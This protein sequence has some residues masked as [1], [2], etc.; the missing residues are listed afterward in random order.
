MEDCHT[1]WV[2]SPLGESAGGIPRLL[3][4]VRFMVLQVPFSLPLLAVAGMLESPSWGGMGVAFSVAL[5]WSVSRWRLLACTILCTLLVFFHQS[6]LESHAQHLQETLEQQNYVTLTGTVEREL[7]NGCILRAPGAGVRVALRGEEALFH[8][9]DQ[10]R[11]T[12][13]ARS[14]QTPLIRGMFDR[15][16][17]ER[18]QGL[19]ASLDAVDG[20]WLGS[21]FS[22]ALVRG[23]AERA[24]E[25]LA[26]QIMPPGTEQD[27]RRQVLCALL[28]GE[29]SRAEMETMD[30]FRRGGCL[31]AFA[32][33][34]LHVGLIACMLGAAFSFFRF[35]PGIWRF[36]VIVVTGVYVLLTGLAVPA[37]RAYLMLVL[38]LGGIHGR[39]RPHPLNLWC[40]AALLILLLWPW[41]WGNIGFRLSFGVYAAIVLAVKYGMGA[42]GWF[43]PDAYLPRRLYSRWDFFRLHTDYALRG[44]ALVSLSAWLVSMPL[45]ISSFHT[46]N[47]Y[48][49]LTNIAIAPLLPIVMGLGLAALLLG[50]V[51]VLGAAA[52]WLALNASSLLIAVVGFFG[53]WPGAYLPATAPQPPGSAMALCLG[54]G[55]S[56]CVLGNPG[57]LVDTGSRQ[58]ARFLTVPALFHAGFSPAALI[59]TRPS[60]NYGGGGSLV[61]DY[62]PELQ[63]VA[64]Q[65]GS[66]KICFRTLAGDYAIY[67]APASAPQRPEAC[68]APIIRWQTEDKT[69]LYV[70]DAASVTY[71]TLPWEARRA[72]IVVLGYNASYPIPASLLMEESG[73]GQL[74]LLPSAAA[75]DDSHALLQ[76]APNVQWVRESSPLLVLPA[77][78]TH[79]R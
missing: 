19:A 11:V 28:L 51:P 79:S 22:W 74:I 1:P 57:L 63:S 59:V 49:F 58:N 12:A 33:S 14:I 31:H 32:V 10:I 41:Q 6:Y 3:P 38:V 46:L 60:A 69:L 13:I 61:R 36:L 42:E 78:V 44:A 39:R 21:P 52:S 65:P 27:A 67:A 56:I 24:R 53:S 75:R 54:Y 55:N 29:K 71:E 17:W 34:G 76:Q 2:S 16:A 20:E 50:Q 43:L 64:A 25:R 73:A 23:L 68:K 37:L 4:W 35:R 70:G 62:W 9:G 40:F 8:T 45:T 66:G 47:T 7:S 77:G 30:V 26:A 15:K 72:D 5:A 18:E 48:G